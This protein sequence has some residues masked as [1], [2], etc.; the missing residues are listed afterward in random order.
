VEKST[1]RDEEQDF[2]YRSGYG[3]NDFDFHEEPWDCVFNPILHDGAVMFKGWARRFPADDLSAWC[4]EDRHKSLG[5]CRS[6]AARRWYQHMPK[7]GSAVCPK[8]LAIYGYPPVDGYPDHIEGLGSW[9]A[10]YEI[11]QNLDAK[12]ASSPDYEMALRLGR[13]PKRHYGKGSDGQWYYTY[14]YATNRVYVVL[15]PPTEFVFEGY[16]AVADEPL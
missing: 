4:H 11:R 16:R 10:L 15:P 6:A 8:T 1:Q 12:F 5:I 2:Y 9:S 14:T 13:L 3:V 7:I